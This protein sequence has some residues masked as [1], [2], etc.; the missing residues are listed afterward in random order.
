[1]STRRTLLAMLVAAGSCAVH[2]E[3]AR[4]VCW[5]DDS[6]QRSC[7]DRVPPE[8]AKRERQVYGE[9]GRLIE[10]LE[11]Q[12]TPDEIA[13]IERRA[14]E[15][16]AA[17]K[18]TQERAAYD[19][20]LLA[21][22]SSVAELERTRDD[23]LQ[24]LDGRLRLAEKSL[25]DNEDG[26]LQ[27]QEQIAAAARDDKKVPARLTRQL[28][29]FEATLENNRHVVEKLRAER[30]ELRRKFARDIDRYRALKGEP[31]PLP[32]ASGG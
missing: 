24:T 21:T 11:R 26:I 8:Y 25:A 14:A 1:M 22:F 23:R 17:R 29:E 16:E 27:L 2:A 31:L 6:G 19:R 10:T 32:G 15:Q 9:D 4:I 28:G 3:P 18:R 7:G 5:T 13:E 30:D 20:F 12:K